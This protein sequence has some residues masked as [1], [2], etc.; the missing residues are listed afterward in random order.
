MKEFIILII[1]IPILLYFPVQ[2]VVNEQNHNRMLTVE[3][4]VHEA[5]KTARTDGYFT[6]TNI[7]KMVADLQTAFPSINQ[8]NIV[9]TVTQTPKY[10]REVFDQRE[11]IS[12]DIEIP[13]DEIVA[14]PGMF[15]ISSSDNKFMFPVKGE[16][17]SEVLMP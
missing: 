17:T 12:Y 15:G 16:V 5:V 13:I 4:I 3:N 2:F 14:M 1:I 10:R 6:T 9:I 8:S 7:N 11:M